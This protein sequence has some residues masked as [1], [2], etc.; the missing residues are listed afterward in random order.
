MAAGVCAMG[1]GVDGE[2][3]SCSCNCTL[4]LGTFSL[5]DKP[6]PQIH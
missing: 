4:R 2:M 5:I 3:G 1:V 6:D